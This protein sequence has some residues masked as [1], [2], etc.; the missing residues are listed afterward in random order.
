MTDEG[1]DPGRDEARRWL[2]EELASGGYRV[3]ESVVERVLDRLAELLP[4]P[5]LTGTLP[6]WASWVV[7]AA[8]LVAVLAVL[9]RAAR[10]RRRQA[11]LGRRTADGAV[12]PDRPLTAAAYRE[13]AARALAAGESDTALLDAYRA[14]AAEADG[15]GWL[16]DRPGRTAHELAAELGA[17]APALAGDLAEAADRFDAV[18]YGAAHVAADQA[19]AVLDL[20]LRLDRP[21][22]RPGPAPGP[23]PAVPR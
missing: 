19:R 23:R 17:R 11:V 5:G 4:S 7:L 18:R 15:R 10:D 8:V 16:P 14:V 3:R 1:P 13:R 22:V 9:T 21:D 20:G 6:G 2:E 12:L